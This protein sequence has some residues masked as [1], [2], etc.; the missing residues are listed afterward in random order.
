MVY[1]SVSASAAAPAQ[2]Q[3][4][5]RRVFLHE[6]RGPLLPRT[7]W[8]SRGPTFAVIFVPRV[9]TVLDP[10][11]DQGVIDAHVAVAEESAACAGSCV[12]RGHVVAKSGKYTDCEF[13]LMDSALA[14]RKP[15]C[16]LGG[17]LLPRDTFL[18]SCQLLLT[19]ASKR[20]LPT[21]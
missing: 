21:E 15:L 19:L 17:P 6:R 11:A 9:C 2:G 3:T 12:E 7:G 10:V 5:T 16:Y 14:V 8:P 4:G 20:S 1:A 18:R 13:V